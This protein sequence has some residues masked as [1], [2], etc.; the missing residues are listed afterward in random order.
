MKGSRV[1]VVQ[2]EVRVSQ[3]NEEKVLHPGDQA[4]T[5]ANLEPVSV[6]DDISWSRNREKLMQQLEALR[7]GLQKIRMPALRYSSKLLER[8]P[9]NTVFFASIPNLAQLSGRGADGVPAR[10]SRKTPSCA[11]GG[12][13]TGVERRADD[14]EAARRQRV[15]GR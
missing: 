9:A 6:Q 8:L 10:R 7:A 5:S 1:S 14:G 11:H 3:D 2:G 12:A 15:P 4:V 13:G